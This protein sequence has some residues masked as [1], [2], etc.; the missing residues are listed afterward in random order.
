MNIGPEGPDEPDIQQLIKEIA[1]TGAD[2]FW[3]AEAVE[4]EQ[5]RLYRA[6]SRGAVDHASARAAYLEGEAAGSHRAR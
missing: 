1:A 3:V 2:P 6:R 4:I 5:E